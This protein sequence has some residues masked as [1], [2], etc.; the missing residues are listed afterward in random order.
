MGW[1]GWGR[2]A[3][4]GLLVGA[5]AGC[6]ILAPDGDGELR[7]LRRAEALWMEHGPSHYRVTVERLCFCPV[8]AARITVEDGAITG[9]EFPEAE[10]PLPNEEWW[11][12]YVL[13][14]YLP[15][16]QVFPYLEEVLSRDPYSFEA[17]YRPSDGLPLEVSVDVMRNA[18]D[19]E[20]SLRYRDLEPLTG[21]S[22]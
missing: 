22:G 4:L 12:E 18:V 5:L 16:D 14:Y 9:V 21:G 10:D 20:W 13:S 11:R 2:F 19:D 6:G 17:Q 7:R 15:V 1:T 8:I 3:A